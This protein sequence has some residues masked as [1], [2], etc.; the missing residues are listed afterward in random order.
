MRIVSE[1]FDQTYKSSC[2]FLG[3]TNLIPPVRLAQGNMGLLEVFYNG[4]WGTVCG[5]GFDD[6]DASVVCRMLG[7]EEGTP[8]IVLKF[9]TGTPMIT[10][11][12]CSGN[13]LS[14]LDCPANLIYSRLYCLKSDVA[15]SCKGKSDNSMLKLRDC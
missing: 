11:V 15:V 7:Y 1:F 5:D 14:I 13:E 2:S 8:S 4:R 6:K 3:Q 9:I 10:N 12:R